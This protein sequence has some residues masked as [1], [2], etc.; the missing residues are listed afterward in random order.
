MNNN[1]KIIIYNIHGLEKETKQCS[2]IILP[3]NDALFEV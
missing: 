1:N 3:N 2:S